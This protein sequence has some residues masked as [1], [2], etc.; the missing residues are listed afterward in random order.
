LVLVI[1][2]VM[3]MRGGSTRWGRPTSGLSEVAAMGIAA[4]TGLRYLRGH[5]PSNEPVIWGNTIV[6]YEP[7]G[8]KQV[9]VGDFII[10]RRGS[11]GLVMHQCI[12][13]D[14]VRLI[15]KGANNGKA[16]LPVTEDELVGRYVG[17]IIYDPEQPLGL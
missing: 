11:G 4:K 10:Y 16:D 2:V 9:R 5:G 1:G 8:I 7:V 12:A 17:L 13:N 6:L 15:L 3:A 14:G